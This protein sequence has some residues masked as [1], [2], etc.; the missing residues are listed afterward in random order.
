MHASHARDAHS[1]L[2]VFPYTFTECQHAPAAI[3]TSPSKQDRMGGRLGIQW[4]GPYRARGAFQDANGGLGISLGS[5][6]VYDFGKALHK[7]FLYG[8]GRVG[9][10]LESRGSRHRVGGGQWPGAIGQAATEQNSKGRR[11]SRIPRRL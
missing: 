6:G 11:R 1:R 4:Q 7:L 3:A 2:V 5:G 8:I 9:E 10:K